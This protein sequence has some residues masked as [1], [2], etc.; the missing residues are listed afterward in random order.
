MGSSKI[1]SALYLNGSSLVPTYAPGALKIPIDSIRPTENCTS[2]LN[3]VA[4]LDNGWA[5]G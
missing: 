3:F 5:V 1:S 2:E 4:C